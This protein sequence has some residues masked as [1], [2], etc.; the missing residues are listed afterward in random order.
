MKN[1][2]F[3]VLII[4]LIMAAC[5]GPGT[6][7]PQGTW[8][9]VQMQMVE[10]KKVTNYFSENYKINQTKMWDGNHFIF[11]GKYEVDTTTTYRFGVGT[12]TLNG[13]LYEED[14][15][16]H[17]DKS[18]EGTKNLIWLEIRN[19]TLFHIFPVDRTGQANVTRHW[20]EKYVRLK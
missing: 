14:I 6:K 3:S 18:Y 11:V 10:G 1:I 7:G 15:K 19:D 17:F 2:I 9:M 4:W 16:Y 5:V 20:I 13:N 12:F 8:Q